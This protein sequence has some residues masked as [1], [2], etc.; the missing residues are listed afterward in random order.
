MLGQM[1]VSFRVHFPYLASMLGLLLSHI[2]PSCFLVCFICF[3]GTGDENQGNMLPGSALPL[4]HSLVGS[5]IHCVLHLHAGNAQKLYK[6]NQ[7]DPSSL[8]G[9]IK[10]TDKR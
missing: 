3:C 2:R 9:K 7:N 8:V 5:S 4:S 10:Q 1:V 6:G